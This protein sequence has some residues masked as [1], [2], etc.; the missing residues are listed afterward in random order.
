MATPCR[1][2]SPPARGCKPGQGMQTESP[3]SYLTPNGKRSLQHRS[4]TT[5]G[6]PGRLGSGLEPFTSSAAPGSRGLGAA[7]FFVLA[8]SP[9]DQ[10]SEA[11]RS[12]QCRAPSSSIRAAQRL[13]DGAGRARKVSVHRAVL[14]T[15]LPEKRRTRRNAMPPRWVRGPPQVEAL[16]SLQAPT[17]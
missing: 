16:P 14:A 9:L 15:D 4:H 3:R 10:G 12:S 5:K 11:T 17:H 2:E 1:F 6:L 13:T 8:H 7:S